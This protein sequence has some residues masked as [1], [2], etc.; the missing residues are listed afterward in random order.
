MVAKELRTVRQ[1][2]STWGLQLSLL[3]IMRIDFI[4]AN[5]HARHPLIPRGKYRGTSAPFQTR[6]VVWSN[7]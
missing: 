7:P 1:N 3:A 6:I 5:R 2:C 4:L